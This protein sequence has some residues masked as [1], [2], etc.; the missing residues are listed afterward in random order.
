M[1]EK[2]KGPTLSDRLDEM[3][4]AGGTLGAMTDELN[5]KLGKIE[6]AI[7]RLRLGVSASIDIPAVSSSGEVPCLAFSKYGNA[8]QLVVE[9]PDG[10]VVPL[11]NASRELR[12]LAADHVA[13]LVQEL[14]KRTGE[15][16]LAVKLRLRKLDEL[17]GV[18][19]D[20]DEP[21]AEAVAAD[22][23]IPF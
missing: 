9:F 8:W 23:D 20:K 22:D 19:D 17:I 5:A 14:V 13:A 4:K 12:L 16:S 7:A 15:E 18:L 1:P 10:Q 3:R 11:L 2:A 6:K 21:V